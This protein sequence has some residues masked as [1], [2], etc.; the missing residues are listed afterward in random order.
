MKSSG[1][2]MGPATFF[3]QSLLIAS[4]VVVT[5]FLHGISAKVIANWIFFRTT[6]RHM[7]HISLLF[8]QQH[9]ILNWILCWKPVKNG[10]MLNFCENMWKKS[11]FIKCRVSNESIFTHWINNA[12]VVRFPVP[13]SHV[14]SKFG[15]S[16]KKKQNGYQRKM[17]YFVAICAKWL[18]NIRFYREK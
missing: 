15:C 12:T 17:N 7:W 14:L 11:H 3:N 18:S 8:I 16:S 2:Q 1:G 9:T 6:L 4:F 5:V 10:I 13:L